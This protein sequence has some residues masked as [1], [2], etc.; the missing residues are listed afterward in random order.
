[1]EEKLNVECMQ[2]IEWSE[3]FIT[4]ATKENEYIPVSG[5]KKNEG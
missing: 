2:N 5:L 1:M 4:Q 3:F